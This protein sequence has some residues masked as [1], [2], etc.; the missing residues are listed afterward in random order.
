M[1]R[2]APS[3]KQVRIRAAVQAFCE[4]MAVQPT[5]AIFH[6]FGSLFKRLDEHAV[7]AAIADLTER[8]RAHA[9]LPLDMESAQNFVL[10]QAVLHE[11]EIQQM[12]AEGE[13]DETDQTI[14]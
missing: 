5:R 1:T 8:N 10:V 7:F 11:R 3:D 9:D 6:F 2:K 14:P 13:K 12:T 4:E